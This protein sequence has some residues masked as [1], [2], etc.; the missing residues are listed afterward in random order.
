MPGKLLDKMI[1]EDNVSMLE[2]FAPAIQTVQSGFCDDG[3][4]ERKVIPD[5]RP[6]VHLGFRADKKFISISLDLS[7]EKKGVDRLSYWFGRDEERDK[8][9]RRAEY[10]LR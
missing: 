3:E 10:I 9:K 1:V 7:L 6:A 2:A 4:D 8:K 5:T